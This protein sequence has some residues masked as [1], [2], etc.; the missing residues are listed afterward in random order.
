MCVTAAFKTLI[1]FSDNEGR[2]APRA[3]RRQ[4]IV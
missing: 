3:Q 1:N 4:I 2:L